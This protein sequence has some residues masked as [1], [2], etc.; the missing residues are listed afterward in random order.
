MSEKRKVSYSRI[1]KDGLIDRNP[2]F[3]QLLGMCSTLAITTSVVN[4]LGM[5][6]SVTFVLVFS[7]LFISVLR[8]SIPSKIRIAAY[9]VIIAGFVTVVDLVLKAFVPTLADSLGL[10]VPLIVVNC[11]ILARA[12]S[13]ASKNKPLPS[14]VDGFAMG[15][16]FTVALV[17]VSAVRELI[18]SGC[19][20]GFRILSQG[21][22]PAV[23]IV[24]PVGGFLVLGMLIAF[25]QWLRSRTKRKED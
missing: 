4:G 23:L 16:G 5:G 20:L 18:G 2:I 11:L 12:E 17:I 9:T 24:S 6:L 7:N 8:K 10:F 15:L 25:V 22:L 14:L 19:L 3:V 1:L 21:Y 13:F